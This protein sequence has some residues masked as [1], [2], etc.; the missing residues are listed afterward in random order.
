LRRVAITGVAGYIGTL[1][2]ER[3]EKHREV[4]AIIGTDRRPPPDVHTGKLRFYQRDIL[5]P[6]NGILER[7]RVDALVHL[8]FVTRPV[9]EGAIARQINVLGTHNIIREARLCGVK[10]AVYLSSTAAY[11]AHRDNPELL[12]EESPLRPNKRFRYSVDKAETDGMFQSFARGVPDADVAILRSC[13]TL[14]PGGPDSVG[15]RMFRRV[16]VRLWGKDPSMQFVHEEDLVDVIVAALEKRLKGVYNV[17]GDGTLRYSET[18]K[19][20]RRRMVAVP[21]AVLRP[22]MG[23]TWAMGLQRQSPGAG[24]DFI[25]Y[26]WVADNTALK[27]ALGFSYRYSSEDTVKEFARQREVDRIPRQEARR[28]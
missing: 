24:L 18:A 13:V 14:G 8:A 5:T 11:G 2:L 16:M 1:L 23:V 21:G 20:A 4:E 3:L 27:K 9:R 28:A 19:A 22:L 10:Q 25:A 17:A 26:P 12:T 7:E 6:F 15:A